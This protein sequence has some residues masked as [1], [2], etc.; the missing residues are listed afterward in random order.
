METTTDWQDHSSGTAYQQ[1]SATNTPEIF[2]NVVRTFYHQLN[3][4]LDNLV[5][6][7]N[8]TSYT[9]DCSDLQEHT[10]A[11]IP[12]VD[13][14][15]QD[16]IRTIWDKS[17]EFNRLMT[18]AVEFLCIG[19]TNIGHDAISMARAY[20]HSCTEFMVRLNGSA[21]AIGEEAVL[22]TV[23]DVYKTSIQHVESVMEL[24]EYLTEMLSI[25]N[26]IS[27]MVEIMDQK[28]ET[29]N[30]FNSSAVLEI[31]LRQQ[32]EVIKLRKNISERF[33]NMSEHIDGNPFLN[34]MI[35]GSKWCFVNAQCLSN[36]TE[37]KSQRLIRY[38]TWLR[39]E[40]NVQFFLYKVQPVI[41][42]IFLVVGITGNGLLLTIFVKH[43]ETRT[44]QNSMLINLTVVDFLSLVINVL[45]DYLRVISPWQLGLPTCK[46]FHFFSN[47]LVVVSTYSVTIISVQRFVAVMQLPSFA[48]CHQSQKTKYVLIAIVW[49]IGF[50]LSMPH[51][52]AAYSDNVYCLGASIESG[53]PMFTSELFELCVLPL[54]VTS[55]FSVLTAYRI[56]RS[57][58]EFPGEVIG[59]ERLKHN[60]MVSSTVLV[61]L[62]GLFVASYAPFFFFQFLYYVVPLS[63]NDWEFNSVTVIT[64]C[65]RLVNCCLNPII[66]LVMSKRYREY[67]KKYC[68]QRKVQPETNS[69]S[70]I[71]TSL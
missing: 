17:L 23:V 66:L 2:T 53:G 12:Y 56:R 47:L 25:E 65:L 27:E 68:G 42:M 62:T 67:I 21:V 22:G 40:Q 33:G 10:P 60:R 51:A 13:I 43:K 14:F 57:V 8:T 11:D 55:V 6:A 20:V 69:G 52:V 37:E 71:E 35:S 39:E 61:A 44:I 26:N 48:W 36:V 5:S 32:K 46:L 9:G 24:V 34:V 49:G 1:T 64:Q 54:F 28:L 15:T 31:N 70:S 59:Q 7:F 29:T 16:L 58:R 3:D 18:S 30:I 19:D 45:L 38:Q 4:S 41:I 63:M 50:I